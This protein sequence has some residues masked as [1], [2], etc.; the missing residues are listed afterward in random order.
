MIES[1]SKKVNEM[2]ESD[3]AVGEETPEA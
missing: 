2:K 3:S 1:Y